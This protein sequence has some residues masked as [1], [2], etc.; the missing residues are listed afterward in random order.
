MSRR[1]TL[2][3]GVATALWLVVGC[4][5]A[6]DTEPAVLE[7]E[8]VAG[9][10]DSAVTTAYDIQARSSEEMVGSRMP[11]DFPGDVPLYG[12]SSLINYGP[13]SAD[14]KFIE[15]SVPAQRSSVER[16]YNAQLEAA[17]WRA[18]DAGAFERGG[19]TIVVTYRDGAPG[20][21]VRIEY[22]TAG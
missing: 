14:R 15:L 1:R 16:R 7:T 20:T 19:R 13:A 21:W 17:G 5:Q 12:S 6:E 9:A 22:P 2:A 8:E 11:P 3:C 10:V 4:R 18:A